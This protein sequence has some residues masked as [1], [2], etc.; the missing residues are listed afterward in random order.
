MLSLM[1][2]F[3]FRGFCLL[4]LFDYDT[5]TSNESIVEG[6]DSLVLNF[7]SQCNLVQ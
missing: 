4:F 7:C 6:I 5:L 3:G 2:L 1:V